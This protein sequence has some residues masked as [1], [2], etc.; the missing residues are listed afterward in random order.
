MKIAAPVVMIE[1]VGQVGESPLDLLTDMED[2]ASL[3]AGRMERLSEN[4]AKRCVSADA[5][6]AYDTKLRRVNVLIRD[7]GKL[8]VK[9]E[10]RQGV[11]MQDW[12]FVEDLENVEERLTETVRFLGG[13]TRG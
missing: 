1:D 5:T 10:A 4:V 6:M 2:M 8:L 11:R 7:L 3:T 13:G 12:S 9:H